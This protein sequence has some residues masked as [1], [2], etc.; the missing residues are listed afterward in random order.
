MRENW[1]GKAMGEKTEQPPPLQ[2]RLTSRR[3][4][5]AMATV[6][7]VLVLVLAERVAEVLALADRYLA[8]T[9]LLLLA[10]FC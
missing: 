5:I 3:V 2:Q 10:D 7:L 6:V 8:W 1:R 9:A 4:A